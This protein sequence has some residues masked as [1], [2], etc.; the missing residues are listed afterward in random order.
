MIETRKALS[1]AKVKRILEEKIASR[2]KLRMG[3]LTAQFMLLSYYCYLKKLGKM[4]KLAALT[5]KKR[6]IAKEHLI[7]A[8]KAIL[9]STKVRRK[10]K[11]LDNMKKSK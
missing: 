10:Q 11:T 5:D 4:A 3:R 1:M 7:E 9:D 8:H 6:A 2:T